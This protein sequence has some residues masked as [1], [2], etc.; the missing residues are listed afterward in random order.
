MASPTNRFSVGCCW[1][2]AFSCLYTSGEAGLNVQADENNSVSINLRSQTPSTT[3]RLEWETGETVEKWLGKETAMVIVDMWDRHWCPTATERVGALAVLVNATAAAARQRGALII[4]SPSDCMGYYASYPQRKWV[5]SLP[6]VPM[7]ANQPHAEP[8]FPLDASDGGCDVGGVTPYTA[9]HKEH[10]LITIAK[11]D[12]ISAGPDGHQT[13]QEM[14]NIL[15]ARGIKN[16]LYAGVHENMCIMTRPFAIKQVV[17]WGRFRVALLR[18]LVDVMYN[19]LL[20]P[21]VTHEQGVSMM[22]AFIEKFWAP[23]ASMYDFL[24][25]RGDSVAA[26]EAGYEYEKMEATRR[27]MAA[28]AVAARSQC[29]AN[30]EYDSD[31]SVACGPAEHFMCPAKH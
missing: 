18:E 14:F 15:S 2:V 4:H 21:Y 17:K 24:N 31:E 3:G 12:A 16:V 30:K 26:H 19:P 8:A 29:L 20:S 10:P 25:P 6:N 7:P 9:W 13:G 11:E 23:S 22:T 5:L 27:K 28:K 1:L